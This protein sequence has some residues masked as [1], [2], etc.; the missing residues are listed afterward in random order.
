MGVLLFDSIDSPHR[1]LAGDYPELFTSLLDS[2]EL[3]VEFFDGRADTLPDPSRCDGWLL[4]GS[5]TSVYGTEPWLPAVRRWTSV[6]LQREQPLAGVCFGHQLIAQAMGAPVGPADAGWNIGAIRYEITD[7]DARIDANTF[8]LIASHKD[9]VLEV[10]DGATVVASTD[11][12]PIAAYRVGDHV[13]SVQAHP[14]F[15]P[16]LAASLYDSRRTQIGDAEVDAALGTLDVPLD[17]ELIG[18]WLTAP[19]RR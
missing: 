8:T 14:E 2:D 4:P 5:R 12:C 7:Q 13:M 11:R 15:V 9:Q 6:L 10:P 1:E 16:D 19:L 18:A 3:S 17:R